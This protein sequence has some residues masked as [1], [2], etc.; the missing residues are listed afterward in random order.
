MDAAKIIQD[1]SGDYLA[2]YHTIRGDGQFHAILGSSTDL[3]NWSFIRDFGPGSSQPTIAQSS[4]GGYVLAWE[5]DP[6]NHV[7]VRYFATR[8][9]LFA[10]SEDR[11][12]DSTRTQSKCAEGTPNIYDVQL[13]P[14][15]DHS[16]ILLGAHYFSNCDVDR[17]MTASL[18]N[19]KTWTASADHTFDNSLLYW[20]VKGNIGDRDAVKFKGFKYGLL[21]GQYVKNDFGSWRTFIYDYATLNADRM[22]IRTAGGST[23]FANPT[24]TNLRTPDGRNAILITLFLPSEGAAPGES[25]EMIYYRTY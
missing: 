1:S 13:N 25:G 8:S 14:D 23:A 24:I 5:Q 4:D 3:M 9:H 11:S 15:I 16:T 2:V 10:G 12:F 20:G 21:E 22:S 6:S 7:A 19:F 18:V 17:Q